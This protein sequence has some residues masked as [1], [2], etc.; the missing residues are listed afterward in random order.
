MLDEENFATEITEVTEEN[1]AVSAMSCYPDLNF[2]VFSVAELP[3][4]G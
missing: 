2:S 4:T 1:Q 3:F